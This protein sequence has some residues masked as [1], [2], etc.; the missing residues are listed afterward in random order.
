MSYQNLKAE[1]KRAGA[2]YSDVG[3]LLGL[4]SNSVNLKING[5]VPFTV[6]EAKAV[7]RKFCVDATL[8]Y[9][10]E[11]DAVGERSRTRDLV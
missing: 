5:R 6:P 3:D 10:F 7:Q 8:D 4:S 1:L 9:L 11:D 2:T